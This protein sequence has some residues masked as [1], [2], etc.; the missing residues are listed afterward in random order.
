MVT[1]VVEVRQESILLK[2]YYIVINDE[3]MNKF[4]NEMVILF[5]LHI[6]T[7]TI[8]ALKNVLFVGRLW[9]IQNRKDSRWGQLPL[10]I[11]EQSARSSAT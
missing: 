6:E 11:I 5:G 3:E 4:Y 9:S 2:S 8:A 7:I 10:Y 1:V